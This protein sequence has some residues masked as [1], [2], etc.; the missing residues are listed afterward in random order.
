MGCSVGST[1]SSPT[2]LPVRAV[3]TH[4]SIGL[5]LSHTFVDSSGGLRISITIDDEVKTVWQRRH[6]IFSLFLLS[7]RWNMIF[8]A[9]SVDIPITS[10][11]SENHNFNDV[12][13][14]P[15]SEHITN[16]FR[17]MLQVALSASFTNAHIFKLHTN[18][19][20]VLGIY[21]S[22]VCTVCM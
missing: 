20:Y 1:N 17:S 18:P 4:E 19:D 7:V 10:S 21:P 12:S 13:V 3:S 9:V 22:R 5:Q 14:K 11:V 16:T 2:R 6:S 15:S 8:S